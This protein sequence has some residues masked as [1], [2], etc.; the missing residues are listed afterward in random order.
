M[1][2]QLKGS[3]GIVSA[4]ATGGYVNVTFDAASDIN[5]MALPADFAE[6][7]YRPVRH[8]SDRY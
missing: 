1:A 4:N 8:E 3:N 7:V 2:D 5:G 6:F